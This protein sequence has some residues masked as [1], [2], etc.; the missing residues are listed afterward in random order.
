MKAAE[1][2]IKCFYEEGV[3]VVFG[4]PGGAVL[5]IYEALRQSNIRHVLVRHEQAAGHS[6]NGYARAMIMK[7]A[8]HI[9]GTGSHDK[10][11]AFIELIKVYGI[12]EL[13]RTG[14]TAL[15]RGGNK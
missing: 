5:P 8:F 6:A 1:A 11:T 15:E 4:Y 2:I 3:E 10:I 12:K 14:L 9:A 7:E 13:V